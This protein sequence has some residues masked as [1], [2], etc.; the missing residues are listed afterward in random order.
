M[1]RLSSGRVGVVRASAVQLAVVPGVAGAARLQAAGAALAGTAGAQL[2]TAG[3]PF[4]RTPVRPAQPSQPAAA[5]VRW[6]A[7]P[8]GPGV[9]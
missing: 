5:T 6:S 4:C 8:Y 2:R 9:S 3:Q 7:A 1:A